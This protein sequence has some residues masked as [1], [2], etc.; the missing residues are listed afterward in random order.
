[1]KPITPILILVVLLFS[2]PA[3]AKPAPRF[4]TGGARVARFHSTRATTP[5]TRTDKG[6]HVKIIYRHYRA[7]LPVQSWYSRGTRYTII[8]ER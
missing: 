5:K 4:H 3:F 1:M 2:S 8:G 7:T 6:P